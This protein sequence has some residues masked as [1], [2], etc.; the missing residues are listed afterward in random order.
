MFKIFVSSNRKFCRLLEKIF[1]NF[2]GDPRNYNTDQLE[3]ISKIMRE[4][5]IKSILE[6]GGVD[7]P[8]LGKSKNYTFYGMDIDDRPSCYECYDKFLVQSVED[9]IS[10]KFD[11]IISTTLL[12]HVP[13]NK[14]SVRS[15][16]DSLNEG[17]SMVHYIPN[18]YH[19]YSLCLRL[20]G[21]KIQK[22]LIKFLRPEAIS[23][24]GYPAFF[25]QCSPNQ[26]KNLFEEHGFKEVEIM[27]YYK[28]TDY[29]AFFIPAYL[30]VAVFENLFDY[31]GISHFASGFIVKALK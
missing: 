27:P 31:F 5:K 29:F 26:M 23:V 4:N 2:F 3:L 10:G 8:M 30:F 14:R 24:T 16:Y 9:K 21:P 12:E 19:F 22:I 1:P 28:A 11:L 17:G 25:D 6:V 20:V 7:R 15:M 18:K 13:N